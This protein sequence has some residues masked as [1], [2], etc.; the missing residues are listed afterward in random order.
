[1]MRRQEKENPMSARFANH[2]SSYAGA[3]WFGFYWFGRA[4]GLVGAMR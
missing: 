3:F 4:C 1:M 2:D